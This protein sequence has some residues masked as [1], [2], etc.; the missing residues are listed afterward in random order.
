MIQYLVDAGADLAVHDLGKKNDGT[1]GGSIEP[2]MPI[3]LRHW[4]RLVPAGQRDTAHGRS[5]RAH[6][7]NDGG[8]AASS[9]RHPNARCARFPAATSI[10]RDRRPTKLPLP[11][12]SRSAI[13]S[14]ASRG[15]LA[16]R[17]PSRS[18]RRPPRRSLTPV[19]PLAEAPAATDEQQQQSRPGAASSPP[20]PA[21]PRGP[22]RARLRSAARRLQT[23]AGPCARDPGTFGLRCCRELPAARSGAVRLA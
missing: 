5:D 1:F 17:P 16:W 23:A 6:D 8:G 7:A 12:R 4:R 19:A 14:R 22:S 21:P 18:N 13:R 15:G 9:I 10:P 2:L 11:A 3:D 20:R